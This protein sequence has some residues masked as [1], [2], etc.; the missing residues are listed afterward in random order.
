MPL[1]DLVKIVRKNISRQQHNA[2]PNGVICLKGGDVQAETA[3]YRRIAE[4]Q[5]LSDWF[6]EEWFREKYCVYVPL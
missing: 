2:I 1:P 3:A 5:P 4:V 6:A